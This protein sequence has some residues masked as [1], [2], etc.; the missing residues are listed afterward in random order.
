MTAPKPK[1]FWNETVLLS[2]LTCQPGKTFTIPEL[3]D[4]TGLPY[5]TICKL[6]RGLQNRK[7]V[8]ISNTDVVSLKDTETVS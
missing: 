2:I 5:M 6:L 4:G 3:R 8:S 1:S 7:L